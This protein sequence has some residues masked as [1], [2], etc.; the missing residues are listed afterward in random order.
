MDTAKRTPRYHR[1][2]WRLR[3]TKSPVADTEERASVRKVD[4][5]RRQLPR[6][7]RRMIDLYLEEGGNYSA[8]ARRLRRCPP[9]PS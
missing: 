5:I 2:D 7:E 3:V 6:K 9:S 8:V 1:K 4:A